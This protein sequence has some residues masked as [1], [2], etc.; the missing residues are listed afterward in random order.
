MTS[1]HRP[2]STVQTSLSWRENPRAL[3]SR[4]RHQG[5]VKRSGTL[6]S[7]RFPTLRTQK[8]SV[9]GQILKIKSVTPRSPSRVP[10]SIH[11][12]VQAARVQAASTK[13]SLMSRLINGWRT[14]NLIGD[15]YGGLTAAVVAL[16]LALAFGVAS[17]KPFILSRTNLQHA[18]GCWWLFR[19]LHAIIP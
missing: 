18:C 7:A 8:C 12:S 11:A 1:L 10:S 19:K 16:P 3:Q 9:Q 4:C 5:S 6:L 2:S 15:M 14:D 13:P 17:G